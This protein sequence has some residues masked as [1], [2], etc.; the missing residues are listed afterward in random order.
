M[1]K[2]DDINFDGVSVIENAGV[3][4]GINLGLGGAVTWL[5]EQGGPNLINSADWGRQV[6]MSFYSGPV[7]FRPAGVG[8]R[9]SWAYLGWNPIQSGDCFGNRSRVLAHENTGDSI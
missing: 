3:R 7:P 9:E 8:I 1:K 5:S 6:Q 4:L 2:T